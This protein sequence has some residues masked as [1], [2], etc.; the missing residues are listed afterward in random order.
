MK[1]VT[2]A[3]SL[4]YGKEVNGT[5]PLVEVTNGD[6]YC[7]RDVYVRIIR[8]AKPINVHAFR[9]DMVIHNDDDGEFKPAMKA[10]PTAHMTD[11]EIGKIIKKRFDIMSMMSEGVVNGD[12]RALIISGA[13]GVGKT[14]E[15]ER[16]MQKALLSQEINKFTHLKGKISPLALYM[17]LFHHKDKGDVLMFDDIDSVFGDE[18]CLNLLKGALDTGRRHLSWMSS[19]SFLA[20]ND[21]DEQF[22]FEGA[23]VFI[24]NINFDKKIE[25][26]GAD[27][28]HY[29]ALISRSNYLDLKVHTNREILIRVKQ[30]I[31][32]TDIVEEQGLSD[33]QGEELIEWLDKNFDKMREVSIRT[34]LKIA[35]YMKTDYNTWS[36]MAEVMLLLG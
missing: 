11:E 14:F 4:Y 26:G 15:L 19:S 31:E 5:F 20:D 7:S 17:Q 13:P 27:A 1:T 6:K 12:I 33:Q 24:T 35:T 30:I 28:V 16:R 34:V 18:T 8:D 21:I 36:D 9:S 10:L 29:Q 23:I 22:E 2:L 32:S 3:S 25:R